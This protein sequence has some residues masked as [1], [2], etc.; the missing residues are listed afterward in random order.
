M[1]CNIEQH[2]YQKVRLPVSRCQISRQR[3]PLLVWN[4]LD[5]KIY[6]ACVLSVVMY[7][8]E[9]WAMKVEDTQKLKRTEGEYDAADVWR[10]S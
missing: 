8:T 7:G 5:T 1:Q 3:V 2:Q 6:K 4:L 10:L 9:T